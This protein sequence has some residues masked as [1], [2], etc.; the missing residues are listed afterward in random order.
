LN[1]A[2]CAGGSNFQI[3]WSHDGKTTNRF[4]LEVRE[5]AVRL[6][7]DHEADHSSRWTACQSIWAKVGCSALTLLDWVKKAEID[8]A[9]P[10]MNRR[11]LTSLDLRNDFLARPL[12]SLH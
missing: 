2:R 9:N 11:M 12:L 3:G 10:R 5:R 4:S 1:L 6:V 8:A 7:F